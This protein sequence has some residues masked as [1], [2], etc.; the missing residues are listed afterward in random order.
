MK[1]TPHSVLEQHYKDIETGYVIESSGR[2]ATL[3]TS[4]GNSRAPIHRWFRMKEAYSNR[5]LEEVLKDTGLI[6]STSLSVIDPF[7]GSGTTAVS[8][9]DLVRSGRITAATV[10]AMEVNPFLHL[11]SS[12]KLRAH[13]GVSADYQ[14]KAGR[15][16]RRALAT[17]DGCARVPSLST[18]SNASYFPA[19]NLKLLLSLKA[20]IEAANASGSL[21]PEDLELMRLALAASVEPASNLR[22]DGRALRLTDGK[23]C[24]NPIDVFLEVSEQMTEDS[25]A[26]T[27][28]LNADVTLADSRTSSFDPDVQADLAVFSPPYPN[29]IDYTEVYKLE[30]WLLDAYSD[31]TD[32]SLQRRRTIRSHYSLKWDAA[33]SFEK[34]EHE[35]QMR[36]LLDPVLNAIP[37]DRY[38]RGREEVVLG[39][40]DDMYQAL[41]ATAAA[42]RPGGHMVV[43]VGNSMHG[44]CEHDYVIASDLILARILELI[45][46][47]IERIDVA[48]YPKRRVARSHFLRESVLFAKKAETS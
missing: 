13:T 7:S 26:R 6:D 17:S 40:A 41:G 33:Y 29:N 9:G 3:V 21:E 42:I 34:T 4:N 35:K 25:A 30:G 19:T 44:K 43:V 10:H 47:S 39:Y 23:A 11:V 1:K 48:R 32:F 14:V 12:A 15:I 38:K 5:L 22:R 46:F 2:Y 45:G 27:S 20:S 36:S 24:D 28:G 37:D 18:F 16:A 31:A 8:A